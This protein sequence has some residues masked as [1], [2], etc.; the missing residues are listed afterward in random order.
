M[1]NRLAF[2]T[3]VHEPDLAALPA[4]VAGARKGDETARQQLIASLTWVAF[5]CPGATNRVY[6][7]IASAWLGNNHTAMPET[8]NSHQAPLEPAFWQSFWAVI[9]GADEG[10]DAAGITEAVASLGGA[11]S[12][13]FGDIAE[14]H[15]KHH[16]GADNP[17]LKEVP[18]LT[19]I[20]A[21]GACPADSLGHELF[22]LLTK[23]GFDAEVLD[24]NAI[25]LSELPPA[26][27]YLN[28]RILQ[29]HDVWHIVAGYT[30][31]AI[32]EVAIS[33][34]QLAQF[35]HNYSSMFLA[36][37][38]RIS[39]EKNPDGFGV[40]MQTICEAWQHGRGTPSFMAIEWEDIWDLPVDEIRTQY[41]ITPFVSAIPPDLLEALT[42]GSF[43]LKLKMGFRI[44]RISRQ[45]KNGDL[46]LAA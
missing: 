29:M 5:S 30:T 32:H 18:G 12:E 8:G 10:Y 9:D 22:E 16:P 34:F 21:L 25:M 36:I 6:D 13:P 24:R 37:A 35:G 42:A 17:H 33:A 41:H 27:R 43:W 28:T 15:A 46:S 23:N 26:L 14:D 31:N 20:E 7:V 38:A 45:I 40:L 3:F 1:T 19:D 2:E 39:F 44:S 11:V 4:I